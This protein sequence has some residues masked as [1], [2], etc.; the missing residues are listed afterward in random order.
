MLK[1]VRK[2]QVEVVRV[3]VELELTYIDGEL[4][5]A[6]KSFTA[7]DVAKMLEPEAEPEV[8]NSEDALVEPIEDSLDSI[9]DRNY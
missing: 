3:E 2:E 4:Q 1:I 7:A 9:V 5:E 6:D 8:E